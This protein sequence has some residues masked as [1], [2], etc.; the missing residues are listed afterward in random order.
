F[1]IEAP[2]FGAVVSLD[3]LAA[4]PAPSP[5]HEPLPRFPSVQRDMAFVLEDAALAAAGVEAAVRRHAGPLLRDVAVF[6]V[7]RLPDGR[8]SVAWRLTFQA[9]DRTLTDDEVNAVH[10]RVAAAVS[11]ELPVTLRGA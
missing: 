3:A 6:D 10:A 2:V 4:L 5:R 11:A 9:P 7:F 8:R 1:G